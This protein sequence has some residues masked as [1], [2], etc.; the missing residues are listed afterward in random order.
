V[1]KAINL[2]EN[3]GIYSKA[4]TMV[5]EGR[6]PVTSADTIHFRT[7]NLRAQMYTLEFVPKNIDAQEVTAFLED[8]Y[9][10][11][12]TPVSIKATVLYR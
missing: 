11:S 7:S 6:K 3:L 9:T 10:G 2:G 4:G 1:V 8:K 5:I 12:R